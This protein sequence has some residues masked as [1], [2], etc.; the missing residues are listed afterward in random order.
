MI[1]SWGSEIVVFESGANEIDRLSATEESA[2]IWARHGFERR[3]IHPISK[4]PV[5]KEDKFIYSYRHIPIIILLRI[6]L[7]RFPDLTYF[8]GKFKINLT[9]FKVYFRHCY[10]N[11]VP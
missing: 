11:R 8:I 5:F 3:R 2:V 4:Q 1:S 6:S 10:P 7:I 9:S